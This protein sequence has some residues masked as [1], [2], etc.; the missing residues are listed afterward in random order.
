MAEAGG[1]KEWV[2]SAMA[3]HVERHDPLWGMSVYPLAVYAIEAGWKD[4]SVLHRHAVTRSIAG[5]VAEG[6]GRSSGRDRVRHLEYALGSARETIVWYRAA[7]PV[8][9]AATID[10]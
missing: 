7:R 6:Y 8:V 3:A 5:H 9:D 2:S 1:F 4:A 10:D